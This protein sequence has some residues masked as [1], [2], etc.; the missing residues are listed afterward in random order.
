MGGELEQDSFITHT[1]YLGTTYEICQCMFLGIIGLDNAKS[2]C[3]EWNKYDR[4]KN[5]E[6]LTPGYHK[7][8]KGKGKKK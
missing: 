5:K 2:R 6:I 7:K 8:K 4:C 1:G 3:Y